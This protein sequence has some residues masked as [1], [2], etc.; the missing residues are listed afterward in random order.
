MRV[1]FR[2]AIWPFRL[3]VLAFQVGPGLVPHQPCFGVLTAG[4]REATRCP[5]LCPPPAGKAEG[6]GSWDAKLCSTPK[7]IRRGQAPNG[8][9]SLDIA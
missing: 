5:Q 6:N 8:W 1:L 7:R 3:V 4:T 9:A 2:S